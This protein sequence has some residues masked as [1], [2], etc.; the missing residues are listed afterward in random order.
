MEALPFPNLAELFLYWRIGPNA[1]LAILER[2][3]AIL[4][5]F[6][7]ASSPRQGMG[8]WLW[9]RKLEQRWEMLWHGDGNTVLMGW[10]KQ[11]MRINSRWYPPLEVVVETMLE[12]LGPLQTRSQL[13]LIHGDLCFNNI[14]CDPLYTS[15][16]LIDPRGET[17]PGR[18]LAVG[19]GDARYDLIKLNHS[20]AGLYDATVNN[21]FSLC[22]ESNHLELRLYA[23]PNH[24]FLLEAAEGMLLKVVPVEERRILTACLFLSMLPLHR[25]DPARQLA[26]AATG[27]LLWHDDIDTAVAS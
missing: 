16:R 4:A 15:V 27:V 12:A 1:W 18:I 17:P 11:G 23:P 24:R 8:D 21:L 14:L 3:A 26:L 7:T 25:E 19:I 9:G 10:R 5:E 13:Q 22:V 6:A 2:L 20:L